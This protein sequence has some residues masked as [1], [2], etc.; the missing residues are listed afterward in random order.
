M[1]NAVNFTGVVL[2]FRRQTSRLPLGGSR[3]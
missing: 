2:F 1:D 3:V